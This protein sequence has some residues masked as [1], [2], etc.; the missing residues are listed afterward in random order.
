MGSRNYF[1]RKDPFSITVKTYCNF[2]LFW[3][4]ILAII[5]TI[6]IQ[7]MGKGNVFSLFVSPPLGVAGT[8]VP[9]SFPGGT[10]VLLSQL[11]GGGSP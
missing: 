1:Q 10:P 9:G 11:G 4:T 2:K 3:Q 6:R 5:I 7:R 8:P